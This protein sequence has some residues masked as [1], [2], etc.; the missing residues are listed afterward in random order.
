M[1]L[2]W[3]IL[4]LIALGFL[5]ACESS[6]GASSAR[7]DASFD[8]VD[9]ARMDA[10]GG[11]AGATGGISGT[12]GGYGGIGGFPPCG[13]CGDGIIGN[14]ESCDGSDLGGSTC[15]S[16]GYFNGSLGCTGAC[17]FDAS[18]CTICPPLD[19]QLLAC[20]ELL[21]GRTPE[22][23]YTIPA[24][25]ATDTEIAIAWYGEDQNSTSALWF[26][27]LGPELTPL[28]SPRRIATTFQRGELNLVA[29]AGGWILTT[30]AEALEVHALDAFGAETALQVLEHSATGFSAFAVVEHP[31][32]GPLLVWAL[33]I[34]AGPNGVELR[35]I[36]LSAD[37]SSAT[38]SQ[39]L[40]YLQPD[41][42]DGVFVGDAFLLVG[43]FGP[44]GPGNWPLSTIQVDLT[45]KASAPLYVADGVRATL[46]PTQGGP[47]MMFDQGAILRGWSWARL[48]STG[49]MV[50]GPVV[51]GTNDDTYIQSEAI[52]LG[53]DTAI[54]T[55][56][57]P[58]TGLRYFRVDG[59]GAAVAP[60]KFIADDPLARLVSAVRRGPEL[61]A[62]WTNY[63]TWHFARL[64]P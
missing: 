1:G 22:L 17:A 52:A 63:S 47:T 20:S 60:S 41:G 37:G 57:S 36:I 61:V 39:S 15:E 34:I 50:N 16:L 56:D 14:C 24:L 58:R 30:A 11:Y 28:D 53:A 38:A 62:L 33:P 55:K 46:A 32:S 35:G 12:G 21:T 64:V 45:G 6:P 31:G 44:T 8:D 19:Q 27:R 4:A 3:H 5:E 54:V 10:A 42:L 7:V 40:G 25:A 26:A 2:F 29:R 43:N 59:A 48:D 49:K 13:T 18:A 51:I 23:D 9:A